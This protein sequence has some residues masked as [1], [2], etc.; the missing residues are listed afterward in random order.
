MIN[1]ARSLSLPPSLPPNFYPKLTQFK[2][3]QHHRKKGGENV[4]NFPAHCCVQLS[5]GSRF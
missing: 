2:T 3:T 4:S 1:P 5:K